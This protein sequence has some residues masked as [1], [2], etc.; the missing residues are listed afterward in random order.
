M[1]KIHPETEAL[2]DGFKPPEF[3][4]ERLKQVILNT[5]GLE[6]VENVAPQLIKKVT[7]G[8]LEFADLQKVQSSFRLYLTQTKDTDGSEEVARESSELSSF[9]AGVNYAMKHVQI[10]VEKTL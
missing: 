2:E 6:G 8:E 7:T 3:G 4:I 1:E 5:T 10:K 9:I